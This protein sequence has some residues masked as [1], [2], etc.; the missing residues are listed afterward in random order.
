MPNFKGNL[1]QDDN[2]SNCKIGALAN[3]APHFAP[4]DFLPQTFTDLDAR[5]IADAK[6][7]SCEAYRQINKAVADLEVA[8]R[9]QR[10]RSDATDTEAGALIFM[11]QQ[12]LRAA[13][14]G[15]RLFAP[16]RA[17]IARER[18]RSLRSVTRAIHTLKSIGAFL[19]A[20]YERGGR[21]KGKG[22]S[23]EFVLPPVDAFL[24]GIATLNFRLSDKVLNSVRK[25]FAMAFRKPAKEAASPQKKEK[26]FTWTRGPSIIESIICKALR[27][28]QEE[29]ENPDRAAICPKSLR[30]ARRKPRATPQILDG[31]SYV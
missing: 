20:R 18:G 4:I 10:M 6:K 22:L 9:K 24:E 29:R 31:A 28:G 23:T 7:L 11:M 30:R 16:S 8:F 14:R 1:Q 15:D 21:W 12:G 2:A 27:R 25:A 3:P 19:V 13:V 5:R 26:I 17:K